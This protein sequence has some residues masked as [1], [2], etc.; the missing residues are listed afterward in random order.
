[1]QSDDAARGLMLNALAAQGKSEA[2]EDTYRRLM[3]GD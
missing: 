2:I 3:A 1:M